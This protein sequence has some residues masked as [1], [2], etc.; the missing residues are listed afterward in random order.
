MD[1]LDITGGVTDV[2]SKKSSFTGG[3]TLYYEQKLDNGLLLRTVRDERDV[4]RYITFNSKFNNVYEGL[5]AELLL[6]H[7]PGSELR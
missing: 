7:F 5:N 4:E 6:H 1:F 3:A 2:I